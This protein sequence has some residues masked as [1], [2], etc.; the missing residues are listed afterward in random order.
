[1]R[2]GPRTRSSSDERRRRPRPG[3]RLRHRH[4]PHRRSGLAGAI[5]MSASAAVQ[6]LV[7]IGLVAAATPILGAY[8]AKVYG[9]RE[10]GLERVP[11]DRV[12]LPVERAIYRVCGIDPDREQRWS[13]Y[14][15]S[16]LAFSLVSVLA[17]YFAQRLQGALPLNP[18]DAGAVP[19][20][21]A[22][23]TAVSFTTN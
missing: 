12:F 17:V 8:L 11:G 5:L 23:N 10:L 6:L 1:M 20:P 3:P 4:L 14:A 21:L 2:R 16:L 18:T 22:F 15:V 13:V 9:A 19:G 7:L